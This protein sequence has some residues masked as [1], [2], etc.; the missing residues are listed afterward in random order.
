MALIQKAFSDIITF[1]RSSNA[2]RIG[3]T[4]LVEYAPHNLLQ[5]SQEFDNAYWT[6]QS[7]TIQ[8]NQATAPDGTVTAD[9][10]IVDA[11]TA[12]HQI[13]AL[14]VVSSSTCAVSIYAKA[15]GV[16]TFTILDGATASN[17]A[18]FNLSTGVVTNVGTGIGSMTPVGNG[19]YRC[20]SVATTTGFRLYCPSS[21]ATATGD[22]VSGIYIWG[23]QLA[24]G[25]YPL[26]YTPTTSAAVYGPRFDYDPVT[27]AA[28]GLLIEEQRTNRTLQSENFTV[29]PWSA[30]A[31]ETST[32]VNDDTALG[33]M[34][35]L[36]TATSAG[37]GIRQV[38]SG[39]SSGQVYALSFYIQSTSTSVEIVFENG[40]SGF[41]A[42]HNVTI[43]PSNGTAGALTG[44]T[45]VS[46]QSFGPGYIYTLISAAA[47]GTLAANIEWRITNNGDSIR[48]GRPQFEAG[49]F[50]TSYI[51]TVAASVTRSADVASVNTLS[52]WFNATEG[53][54]YGEF[55]TPAQQ[56]TVGN[57]M[58][59]VSLS[60]GTIDNRI[61]FTTGGGANFE[62]AVSGVA[63]ASIGSAYVANTTLKFAGAYKANDFAFSSGGG[64]PS[65][66][67]SGS[68]P[69]VSQMQLGDFLTNRNMSGHL[70][71]VAYY[72]VILTAAQLQALTA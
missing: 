37:G 47:G 44:F 56:N 22:G 30:N 29:S 19:W 1:S 72:P 54:L 24:V 23:A 11:V 3:P 32:R 25:P 36:I 28:R 57:N 52:P 64:V 45:S 31:G 50:A 41:G 42:G 14:G 55:S 5:R 48:L 65:T 70:R 39:L 60:D 15:S 46:I 53:T 69:T 17:G 49:A 21:S 51:P 63:Q 59:I 7:V 34:R 20:V 9:L 33:F 71:R 26:D 4:G 12:T 58:N 43:N 27:L 62:V 40:A 66:D 2:T 10:L 6:K 35:G 68:I 13:S 61:R 18:T 67:T 8:P 38:H 16:N